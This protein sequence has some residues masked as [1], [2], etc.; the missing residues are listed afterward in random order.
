VESSTIDGKMFLVYFVIG[1]VFVSETAKKEAYGKC[2]GK[3][4]KRADRSLVFILPWRPLA[5]KTQ[6]LNIL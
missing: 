4:V 5:E 2:L 3:Y 6:N 1:L